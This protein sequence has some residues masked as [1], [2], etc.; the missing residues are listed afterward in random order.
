MSNTFNFCGKIVLG[1][2]TEKF[3]PVDRREWISG[4]M[5]TTVKFNCISD[6]NR[7]LCTVQGG[8][9][10]DDKKNVIKTFSRSTTDANGKLVK[11]A[12]IDIRWE[13]RFN[14]DKID[15]VAAFRRFVCDTG[16]T[17]MRYKLQDVVDGKAEISEELEAAGI[18]SVDAAKAALEKSLAK[19]KIFLS[20]YDFAEHMAKVAASEKF[21]DKLFYISG[22]YDIAYNADK[23]RY[24]TNYRVNRVVLA[25]EDAVPS[26]EMKVDFFFSPD[27]FDDSQYDETGKTYV[28]GWVKYYDANVKDSGF[29][30]MTVIVRESGKKLSALKRKFTVDGEDEIRTIGLVLKVID[31][32]ERV[33]LTMDMLSDEDKEDIEAGLISFEALKR[34]LG[35]SAMGE[36][37]QEIR[38]VSLM[39]RKHIAESTAYTLDD[40]HAARMKP[41]EEEFDLFSDE[42]D[43]L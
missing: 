21:K 10:K 6:T 2:E 9:F 19:K 39:E 3:R 32:S 17:R 13:D 34:Q 11:G 16:D 4:W 36:R 24:Y 30:P 33:E 31:G 42:D 35:G 38:Y 7:V 37:I 18:D 41:V 23:D 14:A 1:K 20:E 40:M 5:S 28:N 15:S 27:S 26:T 25:P 12:P 43:E 29:M 8:K 22:T